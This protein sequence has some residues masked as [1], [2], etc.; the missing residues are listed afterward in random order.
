MCLRAPPEKEGRK[1]GGVSTARFRELEVE[2]EEGEEGGTEEER[3][4]AI[5]GEKKRRKKS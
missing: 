2:E 4:S 3:A 5:R 1:E